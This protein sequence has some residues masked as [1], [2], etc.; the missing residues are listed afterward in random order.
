MLVFAEIVGQ[1]S[2]TSLV[3]TAGWVQHTREVIEQLDAVLVTLLDAETTRRGYALT[4]DESVL[5]P[6]RDVWSRASSQLAALRRLT[7][8]NPEQQRRLDDLERHV[9]ARLR[10]LD[11]AIA[12]QRAALP[13]LRQNTL[14]GHDEMDRIRRSIEEMTSAERVI[15]AARERATRESVSQTRLIQI[16]GGALSIGMLLAVVTRLRREVRQRE[17]SEEATRQNARSLR[18]ANAFLDSVV[19]NIPN[20][21]FVKDARDL[22]FV[23][24]NRAGETLLGAKREELI[25][26]NDFAFFPAE[27]AQA[28][29]DKDRETLRAKAIIDI[30]E[31]PLPTPTGVRWLHTKKVP[32][33][34]EEGEPEYLLGISEDITDRRSADLELRASKD[35]TELAHRELESFSYSV[36]HDLRSPLRSIDGFSQALLDDH[37]DKLDDEGKGYLSRVRN[38]AQRMALLIDDLLALARVSRGGL[39]RTAIDLTAMAHDVGEQARKDFASSAELVVSEG[40]KADGDPRLV[41]ILIENLLSNAFKFSNRRAKARIEVGQRDDGAFFVRDNGAGFDLSSAK[42]LFSAFQRYHRPTEYEGTGIGL[43]TSER[44]VSRHGGRIWA[45]STPDAG[46]TFHFILE[47]KEETK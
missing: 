1:Y 35:A 13:N 5:E 2:T 32:I 12:A 10:I 20:M 26:K 47:R 30:P 9:A 38:A 3:E 21:I 8:N 25:G 36:A 19:D 23:R 37:S 18:R 15:L 33:L 17:Q 41:K 27:K 42:K 22:A 39:S 46:A 28:F 44:I 11:E 14:R 16:G 45:E 6:S 4:G 40:L 7:S 43:A 34:D 31:E 24:F 29:V